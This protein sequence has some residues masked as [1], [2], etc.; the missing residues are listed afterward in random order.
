VHSSLTA[1]HLVQSL[2]HITGYLIKTMKNIK[3][4]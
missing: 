2:Y 3:Q 1:V 4:L